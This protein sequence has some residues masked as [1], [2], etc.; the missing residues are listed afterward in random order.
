MASSSAEVPR[1]IRSS[2]LLSGDTVTQF[3]TVIGL[4]DNTCMAIR[5]SLNV[6]LTPELEKFVETRVSSGRYQTASE[7]IREGLRLLE[8]QERQ[9][10]VALDALK[11]KLSRASA[12]ADR[13]E[14]VDA[15]AVLKKIDARRR[16][17][18]AGKR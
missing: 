8:E 2:R 10:D 14:F 15:E 1:R 12:Q 13:R 7:V 6:S 17:R 5:T 16:K 4:F 18:Q 3:D 9:R 11:Q